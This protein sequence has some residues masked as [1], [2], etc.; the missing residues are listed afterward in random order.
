MLSSAVS[1]LV[2]FC[3][4]IAFSTLTPVGVYVG[5]LF[6]TETTSSGS[7]VG[8]LFSLISCGTF[9][10]ISLI[11]FVPQAFDDCSKHFGHPDDHTIHS[12]LDCDG[13]V[14]Y[15]KCCEKR[16]VIKS[17]AVRLGLFVVAS[18]LVLGLSLMNIH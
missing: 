14:S 13:M 16:A 11:E 1:P 17:Q 9:I 12:C 8:G 4:S 6:G 15:Q 3:L 7:F 2:Y 10:H 5:E 18:G